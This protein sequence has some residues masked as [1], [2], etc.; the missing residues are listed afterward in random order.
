M[1][2]RRIIIG[3]KGYTFNDC[4]K[5]MLR[6]ED[7]DGILYI[8]ALIDGRVPTKSSEVD[9][10][11]IPEYCLPLTYWYIHNWPDSLCR[12]KTKLI[13]EKTTQSEDRVEKK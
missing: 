5:E 4:Y 8:D 9:H 12:F 3:N 2:Y 7:I 1:Q 13:K 10:R 11:L 6:C